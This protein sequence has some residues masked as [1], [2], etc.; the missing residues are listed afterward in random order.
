MEIRI[1]LKSFGFPLAGPE[2]V[3]CDNNGVVNNISIP[4]PTLSNNHNEIDYHCVSEVAT[5]GIMI[6]GKEDTETNLANPLTKLLPY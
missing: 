2:N 1:K 3:F 6:V 5:A 4:E